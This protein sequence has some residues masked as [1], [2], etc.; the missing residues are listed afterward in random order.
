MDLPQTLVTNGFCFTSEKLPLPPQ[1]KVS[2]FL[3]PHHPKTLRKPNQIFPTA[4]KT[5]PLCPTQRT[6]SHSNPSPTPRPSAAPVPTCAVDIADVDSGAVASASSFSPAAS[7]SFQRP[8]LRGRPFLSVWLWF[9]LVF[10]LLGWVGLFVVWFVRFGFGLFGLFGLFGSVRLLGCGCLVCLI[11]LAFCPFGGE[12]D[13]FARL[14][15]ILDNTSKVHQSKKL[16]C[17]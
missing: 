12:A 5:T 16:C 8:T 15:I 17:S 1:T 14:F 6:Q 11:G 7:A 3:C 10:L 4:P 2:F 9:G 13:Y